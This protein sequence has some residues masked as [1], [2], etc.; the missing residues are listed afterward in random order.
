V[1]YDGGFAY[2]STPGGTGYFY[3]HAMGAPVDRFEF[4]NGQFISMT[5]FGNV[6]TGS[7]ALAPQATLSHLNGTNAVYWCAVPT[8]YAIGK[9]VRE[10]ERETE[11]EKEIE[12]C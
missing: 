8:S 12:I 10:R 4:T 2:Y 5:G 9:G 7:E 6:L 1:R 3:V 11:R